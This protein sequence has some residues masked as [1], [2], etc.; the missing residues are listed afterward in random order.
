MKTN[1]PDHFSTQSANYS[2]Y[3]PG[4]P[5]ALFHYL[6]DIAPTHDRAW[7]CATGSGQAAIGL[8]PYFNEIIATDAS[9]AQINNASRHEKIKYQLSTSENTAIESES[10]D[11]IVVAQALHWF[12]FD[13]FYSEVKRLLKKDG[14]IA[15]WTYKLANITADIDD[16]ISR[17]HHKIIG[18]YWPPERTF[19]DA[20]YKDIPFPFQRISTPE[21]KIEAE[22]TAD[23]YFNYLRTWSAVVYYQQK[24]ATSPVDLIEN[25]VRK[26]WGEP[27][28]SRRIQWPLTLLVGK[29]H[30]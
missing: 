5:P 19:V 21:F 8:S 27:G 16:I 26:L 30:K 12:K 20:H 13:E 2:Q 23:R 9:Q 3:R 17:F 24:N 15:V 28:T 11:L 14:I 22:W 4:Y 1:F 10:I 18:P 29:M 7:D 25:E 6:A